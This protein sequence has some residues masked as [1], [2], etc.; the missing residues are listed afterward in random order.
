MVE[1]FLVEQI[2]VTMQRSF[3]QLYGAAMDLEKT[4]EELQDFIP[5]VQEFMSDHMTLGMSD[6]S[7][8]RQGSG[9]AP[10]SFGGLQEPAKA[11]ASS[12]LDICEI[13]D[14][15]DYLTSTKYG[16]KGIVDVSLKG[17]VKKTTDPGNDFA[18]GDPISR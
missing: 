15:E 9:D 4:V 1:R 5:T 10:K 3:E 11:Q 7:L 18:A 14:I 8:G 6:L 13:L 16:V 12:T 17:R 2:G